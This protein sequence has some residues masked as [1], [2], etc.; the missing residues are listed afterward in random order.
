LN[1]G[2][3]A[4]LLT[5]CSCLKSSCCKSFTASATTLPRSR[6]STTKFASRLRNKNFLDLRI[7]GAKTLWD[8]KERIEAE[9][10]EGSIVEANFDSFH[11][12]YVGKFEAFVSGA[13]LP[14]ED[15]SPFERAE[16]LIQKHSLLSQMKN[17][18]T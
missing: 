8:F 4:T 6:S 5:L 15:A 2:R 7:G 3:Q 17:L 14:P 9:E 12:G 1:K 18:S 10:R 13:G 11:G 16:S